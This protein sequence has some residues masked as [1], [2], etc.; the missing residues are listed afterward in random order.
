MSSCFNRSLSAVG[1]VLG[2]L[3]GEA[4]VRGTVEPGYKPID[5]SLGHE[6]QAGDRGE[7]GGI[8]EAL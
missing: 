8:E 1:A 7:S 6:I 2:E 3:L 5:H 4:E